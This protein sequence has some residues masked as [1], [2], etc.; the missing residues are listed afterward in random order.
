MHG[1][2]HPTIMAGR[3]QSNVFSAVFSCNNAY[4]YSGGKQQTIGYRG[5]R[6]SIFPSSYLLQ[7]MMEM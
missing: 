1:K 6:D 2:C 7:A 4:I 5:W 3:H